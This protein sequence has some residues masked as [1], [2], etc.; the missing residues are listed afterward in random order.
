MFTN[1]YFCLFL[2]IILSSFCFFKAEVNI[3]CIFH[4]FATEKEKSFFYHFTYKTP[5]YT[6]PKDYEKIEN[7]IVK[8]TFVTKAKKFA[9]ARYAQRPNC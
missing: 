5:F 6:M 7:K 3:S 1:K 9:H 2:R 4:N 8:V